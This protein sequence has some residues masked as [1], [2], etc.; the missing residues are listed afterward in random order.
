ML[1]EMTQP[2]KDWADAYFDLEGSNVD[3]MIVKDVALKDFVDK[4]NNKGWTT[5]KF[6]KAMK[7]WCRYYGF[8]FN[9]K[10]FQNGQKRISKKVD[11]TTMDMIYVLTKTSPIDPHELSDDSD[12]TAVPEEDKPF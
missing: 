12:F 5:N 3:A 4:T 6:T 10:S 11:G 2:F 8:V 7:S 1:A 9:P